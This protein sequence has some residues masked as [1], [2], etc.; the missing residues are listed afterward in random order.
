MKK[1]NKI[2]FIKKYWII[3]SVFLVLSISSIAVIVWARY[4]DANNSV[5]RTVV[6]TAESLEKKFTSNV[7]IRTE[8]NASPSPRTNPVSQNSRVTIGGVNYYPVQVIVRNYT[9][10]DTTHYYERPISYTLTAVLTDVSGSTATIDATKAGLVKYLDSN[11]TVQSFALDGGVYKMPDDTDTLDSTNHDKTYTF[12]FNESLLN[13]SDKVFVNIAAVPNNSEI[14]SDVKTLKGIISISSQAT[15]IVQTWNGYF[16][17]EG[18]AS[19]NNTHNPEAGVYDGFN[20]TIQGNG[21][22]TV[23]LTWNTAF[24]EL[25]VFSKDRIKDISQAID[26]GFTV[27]DTTTNGMTT[28]TFKVDSDV[29]PRYDLQFYMVGTELTSWDTVDTYVTFNPDATP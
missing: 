27:T 1:D 29:C 17:D 12:Y 11:D 8:E 6:A 18:A 14:R 3:I 9:A 23:S 25:N 26:S 20:Y 7:L 28:L 2:Q 15:E 19:A 22:R 13:A 16:S 5:K 4:E 24:L 21:A 10:S